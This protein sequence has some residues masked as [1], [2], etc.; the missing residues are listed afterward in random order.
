MRIGLR[1]RKSSRIRLRLTMAGWVFL[2][3]TALVAATAVNSGLALLFVM[4]GCMLGALYASAAL[5]RRAQRVGRSAW[6]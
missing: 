4:F 5:S 1:G 2:G 6:P 3:A